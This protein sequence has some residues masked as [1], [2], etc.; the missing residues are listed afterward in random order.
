MTFLINRFLMPDEG[1]GGTQTTET[2]E[3]PS[4]A[5]LLG[6]FGVQNQSAEPIAQPVQITPKAEDKPEAQTIEQK[7]ETVAT[8]T[9]AQ[10]AET[11]KAEPPTQTKEAEVKTDAPIEQPKQ[12][13]P[14]TL[15]EVLKNNQPEAVFKGLG[16][17][18][19][20]VSFLKDM[21]TVD[22][23]MVSLFQYWKENDGNIKPYL[24]ALTTDFEKM[25]AEE[26]MRHQLRQEYPKSSD[27]Q[28][29]ALYKR[30]VVAAYSLD[31]DDEDEL[32]EGRMLL[33]AEADKYR[34]TLITKQQG[35][36]TPKPVAAQPDVVDNSAQE[37][38]QQQFEAYKSQVTG[39][40]L[41]KDILTNKVL[42]IGEG[43]EKFSF[44]VEP[45][46]LLNHLFDSET[47]SNSLLQKNPDGT[48]TNVQDVEKQILVAAVAQHGKKFFTEYA[49]HL[50]SL[51]GKK[52]IESIDN[53]KPPEH[54]AQQSGSDAAPTTAAAAM[55]K[56]GKASWQ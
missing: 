47:W 54:S 41:T 56:Q 39:N 29:D 30:K 52:A 49:K 36:L 27:A 46:A 19:Q 4:I 42:T 1:N 53:V 22:P 33:E 50:K 55:A 38:A 16:F 7:P 45:D 12:Q 26:V 18:D 32:S 6:K 8:T 11:E 43:D 51:G 24:E 25:A 13:P 17:D 5:S 34:E 20:T 23:K 44:P 2:L 40:A 48:L 10:I 35:F 14:P 21:K 28:I 31:S 9:Q 37:A 3:Q 15:A